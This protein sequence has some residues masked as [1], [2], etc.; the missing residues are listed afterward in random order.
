MIEFF[1]EVLQLFEDMIVTLVETTSRIDALEFAGGEQVLHYLGYMKYI[2]GA[3]LY[4]IFTSIILI[5][6][7]VAMYTYLI[8]GIGYIKNLIP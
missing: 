6:I 8:K 2:M 4:T 5:S 1:A 7:G 3:P